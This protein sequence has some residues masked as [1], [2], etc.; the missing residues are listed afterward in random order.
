[1]G[2]DKSGTTIINRRKLNRDRKIALLQDVNYVLSLTSILGIM[3][4]IEPFFKWVC[5]FEICR[6][7][8]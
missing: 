5:K 8:S 7:I 4:M 6:L 1:M 3:P 2:N